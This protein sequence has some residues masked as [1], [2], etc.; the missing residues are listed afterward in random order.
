MTPVM[1]I[2]N[3]SATTTAKGGAISVGPNTGKLNK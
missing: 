2:K 3:R 1:A